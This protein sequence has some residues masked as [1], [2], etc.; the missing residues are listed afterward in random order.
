MTLEQ[1]SIAPAKSALGRPAV[2]GGWLLLSA[3]LVVAVAVATR[4]AHLDSGPQFD[5]LYHLF[6]ARGW[7]ETGT[8]AIE[9]GIYD[10]ASLYTRAVA[11]TLEG[12]GDSLSV[13]RLG[14]VAF[15]CALVLAIYVWL[16]L[17]AGWVAAC[18]GAALAILWPD[19]I[20][21][22]QIVR[23]YAPHGLVFFLGAAGIFRLATAPP[24][25]GRTLLVAIGTALCLALAIHLQPITFIGL[26]GI[27][28]WVGLF[29][30]LPA[31]FA[32]RWRWLLL[33]GAV[34]LGL[35]AAAFAFSE[36][37]LAAAWE[38]FR[39]VPEWAAH[40]QDYE[41]FYFNLLLSE[42]PA[43]WPLLPVTIILACAIRPRLGSFCATV[44]LV[45]LALHSLGGMKHVRYVY[46]LMPFWFMLGGLAVAA[47][48]APV[49]RALSG[50][51][52]AAVRGVA[53]VF[54][55]PGIAGLLVALAL[56]FA[57]AVNPAIRHAVALSAGGGVTQLDMSDWSLAEP[58][59]DP[60][61][62]EVAVLA[63][64]D[65]MKAL[66][67]LDRA[68]LVVSASRLSEV[69]DGAE[70]ARDPRTGIPIVSS[71]ASLRRVIACSPSG[72][73]I[74]TRDLWQRD[75]LF[76]AATAGLGATDVERVGL[77]EASLLAAAEWTTRTI[78]DAE[79]A[80]TDDLLR[81]PSRG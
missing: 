37:L 79:C 26:A 62:D 78:D 39:W 33:A 67:F 16:G 41:A 32:H 28:A 12:L 64:T 50:A 7:L 44:F 13:A 73:F 36:G 11:A 9:G 71:P 74:T 56:L 49:G 21:T 5:E 34:A 14:S 30:V 68:D 57:F 40:R 77:P 29:V 63:T 1:T 18:A 59:L 48:A 54:G 47:A 75:G 46:Y 69:D 38:R 10:R 17:A 8:F 19:G 65:E 25:L 45:C 4:V 20:V 2:A 76:E 15:G 35:A 22:S 61:A 80:G 3:P 31:I 6:A 55:T 43:L 81:S 60:L 24:A 58:V 27:L 51:A 42:Y 53:P 52:L 70:F 23:F 72:I 66:Y